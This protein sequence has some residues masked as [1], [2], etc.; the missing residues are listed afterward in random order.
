MSKKFI[1]EI[2]MSVDKNSVILECQCD[3]VIVEL[4]WDPVHIVNMYAQLFLD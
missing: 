4:A 2:D 1:Y 3:C